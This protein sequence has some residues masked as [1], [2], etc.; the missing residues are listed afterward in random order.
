VDCITKCA[1]QTLNFVRRNFSTCPFH[2]REHCYTTLVRRQLEYTSSAWDNNIQ[3]TGADPGFAVRGAALG[4]SVKGARIE[5]P[6]VPR[7]SGQIVKS[8]QGECFPSLPLSPPFPL[9]LPPSSP[10]P[11]PRSPSLPLEVGP[12]NPTRESGG[13]L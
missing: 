3:C 13:V 1:S 5:A 10:L 7:G 9:S 8:K 12:L 2:I 11:L 6:K 4:S